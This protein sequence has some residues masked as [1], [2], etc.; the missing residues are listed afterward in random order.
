MKMHKSAIGLLLAVFGVTAAAAAPPAEWVGQG[1][2]PGLVI[3]HH[4]AGGGSLIV[5]RVPRGETID[6]WTRMVTNQRFAGEIAAGGTIDRWHAGFV[7]NLSVACPG[8]RASVPARL[9][10]EGRPALE[11]RGDCPRNPDTGRPETFFLRVIGG[12]ADLHLAQ[13]GFRSVPTPAEAAWARG[14]L[15]TV[16]LCTRAVASP[17][18]RAGPEAVDR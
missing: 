2:L 9:R 18:C 10:I 8:F 3:V 1:P 17:I 16:T 15:A 14:H 5:E 6:R 12:R 13:V 7:Q 4:R 11:F